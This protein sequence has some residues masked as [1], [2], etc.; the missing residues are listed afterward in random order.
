MP[1]DHP[2]HKPHSHGPGH[3][4][5]HSHD[6]PGH[7]HHGNDHGH[8]HSHGHGGHGHSHDRPH[9]SERQ[10]LTAFVLT[11]GFMLAEVVGGL[12]SGSLALIADAGHMLTD[13]ASLALALFAVRMSR[14]PSDRRRSYGYGRMQVLAAFVNGLSL[15]ALVAW[16][17]VEAAIRLFKPVPV[18]AGPML[19]IACL[20]LLV[21][22]AAFWILHRGGRG[23]LNVEGALA[24]VLGDLLGSVAAI[25]A[26]LVIMATGWTPVDPL[27]SVLV[28][29][30][31]LRTA[32]R[33]TRESGHILLQGSPTELDPAQLE[34]E[35]REAVPGVA[36]VHHV[37]LWSLTP[38]ERII[39]LHAVLGPG[40][41]GDQVTAGIGDFLRSTRAIG[42][43]TVQIERQPCAEPEHRCAG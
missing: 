17:A 31:I 32:L 38:E 21:N 22:L 10:L 29:G 15:V 25:A 40:A 23:N 6:R 13:A 5:D 19:V 39:T 7:D 27:L 37:H 24:H 36:G 42:H 41:D 20:G 9:G 3:S 35:M 43:V 1:H 14:R 11:A 34:R 26:A 30:L 28:C 2:P 8:S 33:I 16:I 4:H 18:L 12:I